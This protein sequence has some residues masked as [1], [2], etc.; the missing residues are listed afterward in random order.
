MAHSSFERAGRA[1]TWFGKLSLVS[2]L[3]TSACS[4]SVDLS[5][6]PRLTKG[7]GP[8]ELGV[9]DEQV[10]SIVT[11]VSRIYWI[12]THWI[13]DSIAHSSLHGCDKRDCAGSFLTYGTGFDG[14]G[15]SVIGDRLYWISDGTG[16]PGLR[17]QSCN[18]AGC[19][20]EPHTVSLDLLGSV[21]TGTFSGDSAY[22]CTDI[23]DGQGVIRVPLSGDPP[24]TL[25]SVELGCGPLAVYGDYLYWMS[26][27][28]SGATQLSRAQRARI[29]GTGPVEDLARDLEVPGVPSP[30]YGRIQYHFS[31]FA[32]HASD[33]YWAQGTLR[34]SIARCPAS[35]CSSAPETIVDPVHSPVNV[36]LDGADIYWVH[37]MPDQSYAISACATAHCEPRL[38][39]QGMAS[40]EAFATDD[41]YLYTATTTQRVDPDVYWKSGSSRIRRV[42]K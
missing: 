21:Q 17:I 19:D 8:D 4:S 41:A 11:D 23:G 38:L 34:G 3:L 25:G 15:L 40:S 30:Y 39:V 36:M 32:L 29:D 35:G 2:A 31:P 28:T 6:S 5:T 24:I 18:V 10:D 13:S 7:T 37:S 20:V 22:L 12:G 9:I 33:M 14:F 16:G 26:P 27:S 42:P 1:V